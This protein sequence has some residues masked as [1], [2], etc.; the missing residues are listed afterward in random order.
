MTL[1]GNG[2]ENPVGTVVDGDPGDV[3]GSVVAESGVAKNDPTPSG[4][5]PEDTIDLES[6]VLQTDTTTSGAS[7]SGGSA[8]S[9]KKQIRHPHFADVDNIIDCNG[10]NRNGDTGRSKDGISSSNNI[11]ITIP[12]SRIGGAPK[13]KT[14]S[15]NILPRLVL[16]NRPFHQSSNKLHIQH[17]KRGFQILKLLK[18]NWFHYFLRWPTKYSLL[19]LMTLWTGAI[20]FFAFIYMIYDR[21]D[22]NS[23]C[24]LGLSEDEPMTFGAAFAFS[25]ETCTTVGYGLPHGINSYFEKACGSLQV[26]I[27]FQ[28]AWSM[29]FNAFL[30]TFVYNRLGRSEARGAQVIYSQKALVSIVNDQVRFQIRLF[31]ADAK[32]PVVEAHVRLYVV[33]TERPV[34]RPL[35]LLQPNDELGGMLF[36][37]F[38]TVISH[39]IDLY[40][41]LHPPYSQ[42]HDINHPIHTIPTPPTGIS[43]RAMSN[44]Y[45]HYTQPEASGLVLRQVDG[46]TSNRDDAICPVCGES[47]GTLERWMNHVRFQQIV[48]TKDDYPIE[49][50]HRSLPLGEIMKA[51]ALDHGDSHQQQDVSDGNDTEQPSRLVELQQYFNQHVSEVIC[52]VEGIDPMQS[53]TFQALHSYRSED[54]VWN[55]NAQFAPCLTVVH[56]QKDSK[57]S[58]ESKQQ[59]IF[60]VDLDRY[61]D[62]CI[63]HDAIIENQTKYSHS[64]Y[65][66]SKTMMTSTSNTPSNKSPA[67]QRR[68]KKT[69]SRR[70]GDSLFTV[71]PLTMSSAF[72]NNSVSI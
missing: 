54:I 69:K 58:R 6:G 29:L 40:S 55:A 24:S 66:A 57:K 65:Y 14:S 61:H 31:D 9:S 53:G 22:F 52:V 51:A 15:E 27:Y 63:D 36:L 50:T 21:L 38:P 19:M 10:S 44:F 56:E 30:I 37:S 4:A 68:R 39:H 45:H 7:G 18:H 41:L 12:T 8:L 35:R 47:Y 72:A 34:P 3:I 26:I 62:I 60:E 2:G 49:G 43:N 59:R 5:R 25:L 67:H 42:Q 48:E 71:S 70:P 11:D 33:M 32:H 16:R 28:M 64:R 1:L 46:F 17:N 13:P 23:E 20:I